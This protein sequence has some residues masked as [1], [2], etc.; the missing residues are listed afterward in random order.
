M[1]LGLLL[2]PS[3]PP[4]K[5]IFSLRST[6]IPSLPFIFHYLVISSSSITSAFGSAPFIFIFNLRFFFF[7]L[8]A[9]YQN[10]NIVHLCCLRS[11]RDCQAFACATRKKKVSGHWDTLQCFGVAV[12]LS[13]LSTIFFSITV[14]N[15]EK[16][17][18]LKTL[19]IA[20]FAL[21]VLCWRKKNGRDCYVVIFSSAPLAV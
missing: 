11:R 12:L 17:N 8:S 2:S 7:S 15:K 13:F 1:C 18:G 16:K 10:N 6:Y 9:G 19:K 4:N 20:F 21:V 14:G 3:R 5:L